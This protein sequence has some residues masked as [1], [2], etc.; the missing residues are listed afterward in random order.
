M[1]NVGRNEIGM[2]GGWIESKGVESKGGRKRREGL[3]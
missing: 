3:L 2:G 1:A